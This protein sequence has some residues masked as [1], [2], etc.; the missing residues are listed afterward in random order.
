MATLQVARILPVPFYPSWKIWL[1]SRAS[2]VFCPWLA[3]WR[4]WACQMLACRLYRRALALPVLKIWIWSRHYGSEAPAK[5]G[6]SIVHWYQN[7]TKITSGFGGTCANALWGSWSD[8]KYRRYVWRIIG[9]M[10]V[11][12]L[13][14]S[15]GISFHCW[16]SW[17]CPRLL[18]IFWWTVWGQT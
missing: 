2:F 4:K 18:R 3:W 13:G 1:A 12:V 11:S 14:S 10:S 9:C 7:A 5:A 16:P 15:L 8:G 6:F 17:D